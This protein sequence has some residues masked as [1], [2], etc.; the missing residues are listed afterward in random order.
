MG[1]TGACKT[2]RMED[3]SYS[4]ISHYYLWTRLERIVT[5][6]E[7]EKLPRTPQE[8]FDLGLDKYFTGKPCKYGHITWRY[9]NKKGKRSKGGPCNLCVS[10]LSPDSWPSR[11]PRK[12]QQSSLIYSQR[13]DVIEREKSRAKTKRAHLRAY[14]ALWRAG[15]VGKKGGDIYKESTRI[16]FAAWRDDQMANNPRYRTIKRLRDRLRDACKRGGKK[17]TTS[18]LKLIGCTPQELCDHLE[19]QFESGMT[20]E[21]QGEDGWH[22]DHIQEIALFEDPEDPRCWNYTNLRPKW[23]SENM[24]EGQWIRWQGRHLQRSIKRLPDESSI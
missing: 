7:M 8:A 12:R 9:V 13:P 6:E 4:K 5:P 20:W 3:V 14:H 2:T 19:S 18:V 15:K 1:E 23:A 16:S 21:N 17:K 22:I 24:S 10:S 11:N